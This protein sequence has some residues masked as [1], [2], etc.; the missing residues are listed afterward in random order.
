MLPLIEKIRDYSS[1]GIACTSSIMYFYDLPLHSISNIIAVYLFIDL[2]INKKLDIYIH[3]IFGL[4]LYSFI[5]LN[6]LTYETENIIMKPF[7][8]LEISSVFYS[9]FYLYPNQYKTFTRLMF[10][11]T[12]FYY[13]IYKYYFAV[14]TN[15]EINKIINSTGTISLLQSYTA[16]Y[17]LYILNIYWFIK[18]LKILKNNISNK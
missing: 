13:R 14:I 11:F 16:I 8:M 12:F 6:K 18:I 1:F 4:L 5:Y 7:V 15:K 3:H 2:F 17:G 10:F 9:F